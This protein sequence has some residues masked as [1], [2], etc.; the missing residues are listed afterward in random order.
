MPVSSTTLML[1]AAPLTLLLCLPLAQAQSADGFL[2]GS[3]ASLEMRNIYYNRDFREGTGQSKR[4][5]WAQ[6]FLLNLQSGYTRGPIGFG[7]DAQGL[8]G[9]KL[10]SSPDRTG[11]GLLPTHDDGRAADEYSKLGLTAKVRMSQSQLRVGHLMPSLPTLKPNNSRILP[12]TFQGGMLEIGEMENLG[13]S[14]G[15]LTRTRLRESSNTEDIALNSKNSRFAGVT[16]DHF[17]WVGADYQF[18]PSL[19][20]SYHLAQ[21][22]DIYRQ[23]VMAL[24]HRRAFGPGSLS[25]ELRLALSDEQGA[26]RAGSIDNQA[27]QGVLGYGQAGHKLALSLQKMRG[28]NAFPYIDGSNPNLVNFVQVNDFAEAGQRSWQLRYDYDFAR[29]DIPGLTFMTRYTSGDQAKLAAGGQGKDWERNI[30]LQYIV[31]SGALKNVGLR[32]R[33]ATYRS[34]YARDLDENRLI[35]SYTLP[36]R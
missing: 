7:L 22:D 19:A 26:A 30:E 23:H 13:L 1:R 20:G 4:D 2:A 17:Q 9:V 3:K 34:S 36:I 16:A 14:L 11:T 10:D 28:D 6:G 5:E 33:N 35:V 12:Q 27:W 31:Q 25:A 15:R 8:L 32:W 18:T 29:L 21:L 24:T